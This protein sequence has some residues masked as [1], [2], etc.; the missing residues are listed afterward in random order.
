MSTRQPIPVDMVGLISVALAK[1]HNLD[2]ADAATLHAY[3]FCQALDICIKH[4]ELAQWVHKQVKN[5]V[6]G[7]IIIENGEAAWN[8]LEANSEALANLLSTLISHEQDNGPV[9]IE[10]MFN[11]K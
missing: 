5:A 8:E 6:N 3:S 7:G 1:I 11:D 2:D 4:P 10:V 9:P